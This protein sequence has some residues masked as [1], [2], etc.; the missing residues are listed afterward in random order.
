M[1]TSPEFN[2]SHDTKDW[3][4][5]TSDEAAVQQECYF[6]YNKAAKVR[7]FMRK[8]I[9]HS[10]GPFAGKHFELMPYQWNNIVGPAFGWCM[11]DGTRRFKEVG[12]WLPKKNGKS[13]L[14]AAIAIYLLAMDGEEG[15]EVYSAA[16]D[17][18]QASIIYTE[19]CSMVRKSPALRKNIRLKKT[20]K[21]MHYDTST[22]IYKVISAAGFRNEGYNIHGLLF[23]EIHTQPNRKLWAALAYGTAGRQQGI[24]FVT[25]TAGE[26]DETALWWERFQAA[27]KVQNSEEIDIHLLAC[28]YALEEGEDPGS[29][30]VWKRVNPGYGVC[31]NVIEFRRSYENSKKSSANEVEFLR[32]RLNKA[33]KYQAAWIR[34]EY[35]KLGLS[36][37]TEIIQ[38]G[39]K[40]YAAVDLADTVDLNATVYGQECMHP[41]KGLC[42]R[43]KTRFWASE[44]SLNKMNGIN[45]DRY[46]QWFKNGHMTMIPGPVADQEVIED[47]MLP[48]LIL[49]PTACI[50]IDRFNATRFAGSMSRK[51]KKVKKDIDIRLVQYNAST[52]NDAIRFIEEMIYKGRIIHDGN[53]VMDWMFSNC[54]CT[55]NSFGNRLLDKAAS[56]S[57]KIDGFSA[58]CI[59]VYCMLNLEPKFESRYNDPANRLETTA[60]VA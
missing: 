38:K 56:Q 36:D 4:H 3:V 37:G 9:R 45:A 25:S 42:I 18:N 24:I 33:T 6:D 11:P 54:K 55:L 22:S 8:F 27:L 20:V 15:A 31:V 2:L 59:M 43:I 13:T 48:D 40:Q 58:L 28:V 19:A 7:L 17:R 49:T 41:E 29:E 47:D 50:G 10:K 53:P 44:E 12:V 23:D 1:D 35:W 39:S 32:Y 52:M 16:S 30:E 51:L 26:L 60:W 5:T 46:N 14:M 57:K 21:E 34:Q